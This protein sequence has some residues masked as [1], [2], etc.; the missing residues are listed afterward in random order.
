LGLSTLSKNYKAGLRIAFG[1]D[2]GVSA[3][4]QNAREFGLM[5]K[6]G[7]SPIDAIKSATIHAA[8]NIGFGNHIG[9]ERRL[10]PKIQQYLT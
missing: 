4:G 8:Y 3:H 2:S 1:I 5:V 9:Y 10:Y 7:M 6:A